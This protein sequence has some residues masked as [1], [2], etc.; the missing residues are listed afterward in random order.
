M[1]E[2]GAVVAPYISAYARPMR[3]PVLRWRMRYAT[4]STEIACGAVGLRASYA[5][6]GTDLAHAAVRLRARYAVSGADLAD[7][8]LPGRPFD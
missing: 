4:A 2:D 5:V 7:R 1:E 8:T 6:S 3:C